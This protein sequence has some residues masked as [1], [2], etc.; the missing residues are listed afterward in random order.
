MLLDLFNRQQDIGDTL[1]VRVTP[2][3]AANRI[4]VE[5]LTDGSRLIRVYVT[6][7][8]E[9][10]K[11]NREVIKLLAKELGLPK[12][13]LTITQGLTSKDKVIKISR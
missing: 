2:K 9:D 13:A 7:V 11:A 8:P 1:K 6:T 3:A 4:K 12:S 10:G 5:Y